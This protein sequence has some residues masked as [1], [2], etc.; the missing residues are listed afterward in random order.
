[1]SEHIS[2]F[3]PSLR[4][5]GAERFAV[6]LCRGLINQNWHVHLLLAKAEGD[7]LFQLPPAVE[8][9]DFACSRVSRSVFR[10]TKYLRQY[11]PSVLLS[12][13]PHTNLVALFAKNLAHIRTKVVITEH[14]FLD[15][16]WSNEN[17]IK[18]RTFIWLMRCLYPRADGLVAVSQGVAKFIAQV[19]QVPL[20]RIQVIYNPVITPEI[21]RLAE[22][23][24]EHPW[25]Q[26]KEHKIVLGAGRLTAQKDFATLLRAFAIVRKQIPCKLVILGEGE[27]RAKLDN[28]AKLMGIDEDVSMPGLV[29]NPYKYMKS[30]DV[31]VLSSRWEGFGNVVAESL[32]LGTPIVSTD[33]PYGP[34]EILQNGRL[35][36]L[37]PVGDAEAI[38]KAITSALTEPRL[39]VTPEIYKPFTINEVTEKYIH[40]FRQ[41]VTP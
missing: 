25:F 41:I 35:G 33:C 27:E 6:N 3:I 34:A 22:E 9:F 11:Q 13:M 26:H 7:L 37:C 19:A 32:A 39:W 20:D 24:V 8:V 18:V 36:R 2:I 31:F 40:L 17:P 12:V 5:G 16:Q 10:L 30:A 29:T 1:M 4:L 23:P 21:F 28:L 14:N 38:A 15:I